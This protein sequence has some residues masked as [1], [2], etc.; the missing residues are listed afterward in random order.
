[1]ILICILFSVKHYQKKKFSVFYETNEDEKS[2]LKGL[3]PGLPKSGI[4][5]FGIGLYSII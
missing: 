3:E 2:Y 1:M 5:C 4:G